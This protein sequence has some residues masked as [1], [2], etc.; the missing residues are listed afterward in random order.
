MHKKDSENESDNETGKEESENEKNERKEKEE[1]EEEKDQ[2]E[3]GM[4]RDF[5]N[6]FTSLRAKSGLAARDEVLSP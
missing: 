1:N 4:A 6:L 3:E 5:D 2:V